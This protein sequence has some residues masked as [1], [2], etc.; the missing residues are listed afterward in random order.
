MPYGFASTGGTSHATTV[1]GLQ[2]GSS[3]SYFV[4]C[5]DY[6]GNASQSDY[7][8]T[9][10]VAVQ[11]VSSN[12]PNPYQ[13]TPNS[14]SGTSQKFTF[15]ISDADGYQTVQQVDT[16]IDTAVGRT[17]SCRVEYWAPT[18]TLSLQ[19]NENTTWSQ[20][21][22]GT[23]TVLQNSQCSVNAASS[24][25]YGSGSSLD[26]TLDIT[27][28]SAYQGTKSIF[29]FVADQAGLVSSWKTLG[30]WTIAGAPPPPSS[31][32]SVRL[33]P[34]S[35]AGKSA[36]FELTV[37]DDAGYNAVQQVGLFIGET[38]GALNSCYIEYWAS[39]RTVAL[40]NNLS[41][42]VTM[43]LPGSTRVLQ[44]SQCVVY[45]EESTI[46]T[47]GNT[48]TLRLSVEFKSRYRG[49]QQLYTFASDALGRMTPW[50]HPGSWDIR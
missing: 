44:N 23:A 13:V 39:T 22:L 30:S 24:T 11:T 25:V 32:L 15:R 1:G 2:S 14:G 12:A 5:M 33:S 18:R 45:L 34:A 43:G 7:T 19:S 16:V 47:S 46:V 40:W 26:L 3:Y 29:A 28:A 10:S 20:A 37:T 48:M 9:F 41:Y 42:A 17:N 49:I 50:E 8:I 36:V 21:I 27:F 31:P 35:G 38:V 4:R 6:S